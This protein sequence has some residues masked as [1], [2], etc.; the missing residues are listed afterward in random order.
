MEN[1]KTEKTNELTPS[2]QKICDML[3]GGNTPKEIA[4]S[5]N[6]AYNTV[7]THQK[8][9][10]RKL[11]VNNFH[12]LLVKFKTD[13]D[14]S[15]REPSVKNKN[16][17]LIIKILISA[18]A[19]AVIITVSV[20][21]LFQWKEKNTVNVRTWYAIS[22][23]NSTIR[24]SRTNEKIDGK[25]RDCVTISGVLY[26]DKNCVMTPLGYDGWGAPFAGAYGT[27]DDTTLQNLRTMKSFSMKVMGDGN[28]YFFRLPT[29]ETIEGD[30]WLYV[31]PTV[32]DE[33]ITVSAAVLDDFNRLGWSGNDV[34]FIQNNI[35]FFQIQAVNPGPYKLKFWDIKLH[36]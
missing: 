35:M 22:D 24:V 25:T 16:P 13:G 32:K 19:L 23:E 21:L 3:L 6:I 17:R 20:L 36:R 10:Y 33:I 9:I 30:H 8:N 14:T 2:E 5:L 28:E 18:A 27:P 31:F 15:V 34:E 1:I 4:F 7:K 29:M 12:G 11:G 26:D